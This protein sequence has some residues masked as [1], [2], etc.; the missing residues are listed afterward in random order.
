MGQVESAEAKEEKA[1]QQRQRREVVQEI[2]STEHSYVAGLQVCMEVFMRPLEQAVEQGRPIIK[3]QDIRTIFSVVKLLHQIHMPFAAELKQLLDKYNDKKPFAHVFINHYGLFKVYRDYVNN[4]NQSLGTL[5]ERCRENRAFA[6]FL[7]SAYTAPECQGKDLPSFLI[8]PIQRLPRYV[9]LLQELLRATPKSHKDYENVVEALSKIKLLTEYINLEKKFAENFQKLVEIQNSFAEDLLLAKS[10]KRELLKEGDY[11][12]K[13]KG[14]RKG[15]NELHF[16]L[17][18][19]IVIFAR[20]RAGFT[21]I[22]FASSSSWT[23]EHYAYLPDT[24]LKDHADTKQDQHVV[25]L[26][27]GDKKE[28]L[29][30]LPTAAEKDQWISQFYTIRSKA[31]RIK[32]TDILPAKDKKKKKDKKKQYQ[33][34]AE[35]PEKAKPVSSRKHAKAEEKKNLIPREQQPKIYIFLFCC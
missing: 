17:F 18:N 8:T 19:D 30:K 4:Y 21:S 23:L 27:L 1:K 9:L 7:S 31:H 26:A 6:S 20:P 24:D 10:P 28:Y 11:M 15:W 2:V 3:E 22:L 5:S 35:E 13:K 16:F 25:G 14:T 34:E 32:F 12:V 29:I 33:Q